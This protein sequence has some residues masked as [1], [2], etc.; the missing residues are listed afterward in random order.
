MGLLEE[1][2]QAAVEDSVPLPVVLRKLR[3]LAYRLNHE[4]LKEWVECELNGYP[5]DADLPEYRRLST[6]VF[7]SFQCG[8]MYLPRYPVARQRVEEIL[9]EAGLLDSRVERLFTNSFYEGVATLEAMAA[10][11]EAE[12]G[13]AWSGDQV[14][15]L[16]QRLMPDCGCLSVWRVLSRADIVG[17]LDSVRNRVQLFVLELEAENPE[18]DAPGAGEAVSAERVTQIFQTTIYGE[19]HQVAI[20]GRDLVQSGGTVVTKGD[21]PALLS[22]LREAGVEGELLDELEAALDEDESPEGVM[23]PKVGRWLRK[24]TGAVGLEAGANLITTAILN[25]LGVG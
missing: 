14:S 22:A 20:S 9:A 16:G 7:G 21:R 15:S 11:G 6:G 19:G 25:Y 13:N 18:A 12:L 23:G 24:A 5:T 4:P 10:E 17:L 8:A 1:I 2:A 3:T